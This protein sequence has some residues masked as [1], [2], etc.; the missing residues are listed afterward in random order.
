[1][2]RKRSH[3]FTLIELLVVIAIIGIL[4]GLLFAGASAVRDA[5]RRKKAAAF[6]QTLL[7]A[8]RAYRNDFDKWPGQVAGGATNDFC[9]YGGD[10]PGMKK[11]CDD[12]TNNARGILYIEFPPNMVTN[13]SPTST[14]LLDPWF[15]PYW[16][17]LDYDGDGNLGPFTISY[18]GLSLPTNVQHETV[19]VFSWGSRP[20]GRGQRL[21]ICSWD[22]NARF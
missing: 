8:I 18:D 17:I 13:V 22:P 7:H 3:G 14:M 5:A 9:R 21:L 6:E 15:T 16:I 10:G 12:L 11:V 4:G 19:A 20:T 1:M 2:T